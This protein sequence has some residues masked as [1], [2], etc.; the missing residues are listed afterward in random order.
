VL[1]QR[2]L[3]VLSIAGML[4]CSVNLFAFYLL[5][6]GRYRSNALISLVTAICTLVASVVALPYFGWPA[7]GWSARVGTVAQVF[8][9]V[10]LLRQSFS[11][12]DLWSRVARFVWLPLGTGIVTALAVRYRVDG[13][14]LTLTPL[15]WY[16]VG[17]YALAAGVILVIVV[18]VSRIGPYD[19]T[20]WR[21]MCVIA[22]RLLPAKVL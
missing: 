5:A 18:T 10:I 12:A 22:S 15:W 17:S 21:D 1:T 20:C 11:L 6:S 13:E 16:V 4:G 2:V 3:V 14:P 9:T 8:V 19:A 7:A